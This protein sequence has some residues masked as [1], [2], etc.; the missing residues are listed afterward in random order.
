MS[1]LL[2][3]PGEPEVASNNSAVKSIDRINLPFRWKPKDRNTGLIVS[4]TSH[5][6]RSAHIVWVVPA[7]QAI[8][9]ATARLQPLNQRAR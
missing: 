7:A 8:E 3:A 9:T 1:Q 4:A 2:F 5:R 6:Q